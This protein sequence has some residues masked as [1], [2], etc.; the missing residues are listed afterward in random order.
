[1]KESEP[2]ML[3]CGGETAWNR[4]GPD[5]TGAARRDHHRSVAGK[6]GNGPSKEDARDTPRPSDTPTGTLR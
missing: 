6:H 2:R 4:S 3:E 1:M 5:A